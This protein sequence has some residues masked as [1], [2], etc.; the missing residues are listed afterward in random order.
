M[1]TEV[2]HSR[3]GKRHDLELAPSSEQ[4]ADQASHLIPAFGRQVSRLR[5]QKGLSVAQAAKRVGISRQALYRI[6]N[7]AVSS[8]RFDTVLRIAEALEVNQSLLLSRASS[9]QAQTILNLMSA[10][11]QSHLQ[12]ML[13]KLGYSANI[14]TDKSVF[15]A[16]DNEALLSLPHQVKKVAREGY[17]IREREKTTHSCVLL[18]GYAYR[19]KIVR[20]G[21]RQ[22]VAVHIKGDILD[23]QNSFLGVADHSVQALTD[24]EVAFIPREAVKK[25]AVERPRIGMAM[26]RD[27]LVDGS[28]FREWIANIG[29][30][31]VRERIAHLLCE[32][33]LRLKIAGLGEE[34]GHELPMTTQQLADSVGVTP[35]HVSRTL[36]ALE[37][38]NL[39]DRQNGHGIRVGDW[40]KLAAA[41]DFD[42]N[43]L[44]LRKGEPALD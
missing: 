31:N 15:D 24:S 25:L 13:D 27:T 34:T 22:I 32:F 39:I 4:E 12:P 38:E 41:G 19:H 40:E 21:A 2:E 35:V 26:W 42:S 29:R 37:A 36:K 33:S 3:T 30:R 17:I 18:S 1:G 7:G 28:I 20:G 10:L 14:D 43:Y 9:S 5:V 23:L 16:A 44:H 11:P 8:P 6:E